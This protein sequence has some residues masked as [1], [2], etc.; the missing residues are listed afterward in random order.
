MQ[1]RCTFAPD[2]LS[3]LR[4]E[5]YPLGAVFVFVRSMLTQQWG[6]AVSLYRGA[7]MQRMKADALF[8]DALL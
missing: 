8:N 7:T 6:Q 4:N 5:H 1:F 3:H 2:D